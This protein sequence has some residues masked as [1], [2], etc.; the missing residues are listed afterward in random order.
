[1]KS[2]AFK[3]P[4]IDLVGRMISERA[5]EARYFEEDL[6]G[7]VTIEMVEVAGGTF[8]MGSPDAEEDRDKNEG[9]RHQ[10]TVPT[11]FMSRY[12]I[13]QAQWRAVARLPKV[14]R[15]LITDPSYHKGDRLPVEQIAWSD[16]VEFCARLWKRTGRAYRLPSEA[17]WEY[18]CRA[19]ATAAFG[20]G[21]N[22]NGDAVN[23]N[24]EGP[25]KTA[26]T[27]VNREKPV[28][29]GSLGFA[30]AFGLYDMH[31]N[32][33]EWCEDY[34]HDDYRNA[35]ADGRAWT[36]GGDANFRPV[37]GGTWYVQAKFCR[38]AYRLKTEL[39]KMSDNIGFRIAWSGGAEK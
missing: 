28:E 29:V 22:I 1:M 30:N 36:E 16:A 31:G 11:F 12:E 27:A 20:F 15:D 34:W 23:F 6:G 19:G 24:G 32:V 3:T 38:A 2:F 4:S 14:N 8:F 7:G 9:P 39:N 35:P 26:P 25:Y 5:G 18:A 37:R 13:T 10:V 17:E 21:E 33:G